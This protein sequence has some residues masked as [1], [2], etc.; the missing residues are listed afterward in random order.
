M[1]PDV[2]HSQP[3]HAR[4]LLPGRQ[5]GRTLWVLKRDLAHDA[6]TGRMAQYRFDGIVVAV[7]WP[8]RR[9][10][11]S[12]VDAGLVHHGDRALDREW[13]WQLRLRPGNPFPVVRLRLPQMDLRIDDHAAVDLCYR[14]VRTLCRERGTDGGCG[15][16]KRAS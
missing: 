4:L 16:E 15:A 1:S 3:D 5:Q 10:D 2:D 11:D 6:E 14:L 8:G 12:A 9:D 7:A 13:D